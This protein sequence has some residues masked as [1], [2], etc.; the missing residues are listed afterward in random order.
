MQKHPKILILIFL[1]IS[2]IALNA[3]D[4]NC[5]YKARIYAGL[6]G[7]DSYLGIDYLKDMYKSTVFLGIGC[8]IGIGWTGYV[9][10]EPLNWHGLSPFISSGLSH[11]FGG[12]LIVSPETSVFSLSAGLSYLPKS[13]WIIVP[14]ISI[15]ITSYSLLAG[16]SEKTN[17]LNPLIKIGL[18]FPQK[19]TRFKDRCE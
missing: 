7:E 6:G 19:G 13:K 8:G 5:Y 3:Q 10:Y 18:E 14:A 11:S 16:D 2:S 1:F 15:G 17:R 12:T 4:N 9:R